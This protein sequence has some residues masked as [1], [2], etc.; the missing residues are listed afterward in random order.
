MLEHYLCRSIY[1]GLSQAEVVEA[2]DKVSLVGSA[3]KGWVYVGLWPI[4]GALSSV[5]ASVSTTA[6]V[7]SIYPSYDRRAQEWEFR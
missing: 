7:F 2:L 1:Q 3:G 5:A 6:S 4:A